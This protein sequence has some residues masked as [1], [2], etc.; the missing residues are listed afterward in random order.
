MQNYKRHSENQQSIVSTKIN[1]ATGFFYKTTL[2]LLILSTTIGINCFASESE[3]KL[4]EFHKQ[5][6]SF[7][8]EFSQV[9]LDENKKVLQ[10]ANGVFYLMRPGKFRWNYVKPDVQQIVSNGKKIWIYDQEL[11]Q[12]TIKSLKKGIGKTPARVLTESVDLEK[13]FKIKDLGKISGLSWVEL[14]P[15][16]KE[17][18]FLSVKIGFD[19]SLR[20]MELDDKLKQKTKIDF[21]N[22]KINP[23]LKKQIFVFKIPKGVDVIGEKKAQ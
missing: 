17:S 4:K 13:E 23:E 8:A 6:K 3:V 20:K 5:V 9:L 18:E 19:K 1:N 12:V 2:L 14:T 22:L 10:T 11:E 15:K 21:T 7:Q 16:S